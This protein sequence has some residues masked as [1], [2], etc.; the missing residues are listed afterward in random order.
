M[1]SREPRLILPCP[2]PGCNK[3]GYREGD[4]LAHE[5]SFGH[6]RALSALSV[7]QGAHDIDL[8]PRVANLEFRVNSLELSSTDFNTMLEG[9]DKAGADIAEWLPLKDLDEPIVPGDVVELL[10]GCIS[11]VITR[12]GLVFVVSTRPMF[13]GNQPQTTAERALASN[14]D[15][16]FQ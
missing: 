12:R 9:G 1:A 2:V 15:G 13:V 4:R 16:P 5:R 7:L 6:K 8:T 10:D 14:R 11:R 3:N